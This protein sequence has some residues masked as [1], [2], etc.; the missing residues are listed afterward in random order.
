MRFAEPLLAAAGNDHDRTQHALTL[1]MAFWNLAL[2]HGEE[3]DKMLAS[4]VETIVE[5][6][7]RAI[8][9]RA[10][11]ADMVACH[12]EMFPE[13]HPRACM[14]GHERASD[15]ARN[16]VRK[17]LPAGEWL[18]DRTRRE[19]L[20]LK[21]AAVAPL[22]DILGDDG[23]ATRSAPGCGYAPVHAVWLLT[24]LCA[25]S[26]I[27]AMLDVLAETEWDTI[28]HRA[29]AVFLMGL[30]DIPESRPHSPIHEDHHLL[31]VGG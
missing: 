17:L 7:P 9:L 24:E 12:R 4:F 2:L 15:H 19:I 28:L 23:L 18:P 31:G 6:E 30:P 16:T 26:A 29:E 5:G 21:E 10:I 13:L 1:A 27:D 14:T 22:L 11:A 8:E 20:A 25:E 3:H